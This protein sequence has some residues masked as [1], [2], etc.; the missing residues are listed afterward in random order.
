M[1][2]KAYKSTQNSTVISVINDQIFIQILKCYYKIG[3]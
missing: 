1:K 3:I 2:K